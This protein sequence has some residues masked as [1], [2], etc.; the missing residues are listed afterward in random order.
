MSRNISLLFSSDLDNLSVRHFFTD[1]QNWLGQK[2]FL[3]A[4]YYLFTVCCHSEVGFS[5]GDKTN[6][7]FADIEEFSCLPFSVMMYSAAFK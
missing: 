4:K 6:E 7:K 5:L 2:L 3:V 1:W